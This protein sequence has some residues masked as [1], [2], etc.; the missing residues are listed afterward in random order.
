MKE[1]KLPVRHTLTRED[2]LLRG[3]LVMAGLWLMVFILL[4][5]LQVILRSVS[6]PKG[7]LIG[8]T[9]Y[10]TYFSTPRLVVSFTN[11]L[12][13]AICSTILT[14]T[15]AFIF[16]YGLTHT[17]M[18]GKRF[19]RM[20]A[21]LPLHAPS[22]LEGIAFVYLF[23]KQGLFTRGF[24]GYFYNTFGVNV[25]I[26]IGLYTNPTGIILAEVFY[27]FPHALLILL[28]GLSLADARL[29][30]AALALR[31]TPI[32]TFFTVTLPG[33]RYGLLSAS[34]VCFT[35]AFT[36][37]GIPKVLGPNYPVLATDIYKKVIGQQDFVM[38]ST[39]SMLLLVPTAL[40]FILDRVVQRQQMALLTS[41][42]VPFQ[43]KASPRLDWTYS[44]V[45]SLISLA[46]LTVLGTALM[47][48]IINLWPY[49]L[50]L[51]GEN[52]NF[53]NVAGV[54]LQ[55]YLNSV[56]LAFWT[57]I[58]GTILVF[59]TAYVLEK[60]NS[61]QRFRAVLYF[62]CTLPGAVPG[63][64]LGLSY[65]FFFNHPANPLNFI[66]G[67]MVILVLCTVVHFFTVAFYTATAALK[68][69]SKEFDEVAASLS[70]PFWV[71][72]LRV[73]VPITLPAILEIGVYYFMHAL[74][75]VSAVIFL[76]AAGLQLASVAIVSM[77][78]AGDTAR[79]AA[80]SMLIFFTGFG[81]R[82]LYEVVTYGLK[83]RMQSWRQGNT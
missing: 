31:A 11:S 65:I 41:R 76:Y 71:T 78:D 66:Y 22:L 35:A 72:L 20:V 30:E 9:N 63:L 81:V 23:G 49:D 74:T 48:S 56:Q 51:S 42:I 45:S 14:V 17:C 34:L 16:A 25:S 80:L 18:R 37:F 21:M 19:F 79:A 68:Q 26:N 32:R 77:D 57:A 58:F 40:G 29:Y 64:V 61:W 46:I 6:D 2:V 1:L 50:S 83:R 36:D 7:N 60:I 62:L 67:T 44:S 59:M 27:L 24:F 43:P 10:I 39:V 47:A 53:E 55:I 82:I 5:L 70:I 28:I 75:T 69:I 38:G 3:I 12:F 33:V 73:T 54:G 15:L 52:Y 4:P 13:V 8:L